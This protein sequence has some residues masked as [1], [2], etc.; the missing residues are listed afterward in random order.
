[1]RPQCIAAERRAQRLV[2][3]VLVGYAAGKPLAS[4]FPQDRESLTSA[5]PPCAGSTRSLEQVLQLL[6]TT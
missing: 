5:K 2:W 4:H 1:M 6:R 3:T